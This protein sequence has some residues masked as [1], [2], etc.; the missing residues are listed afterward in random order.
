MT[1]IPKDIPLP[2]PAPEPLL[3]FLLVI[4]FLLHILFVNLMAGGALLTVYYQVRGLKEPAYDAL[5]REISRTITVNKSLAVV[6]GVGPLLAINTLYTVY[7]YSASALIGG[8]WI[9]IVP[10]VTIAFLLAY[11][12]KYRW[13]AL[14]AHRRMHIALGA[15]VAGLFLFVPMIFLANANLMLFPARWT[16]V[17]GL[18]SALALPGVLPRYLHF[19]LASLAF[20]GLFLVWVFRRPE[21]LARLAEAGFAQETLIRLGYR[22]AFFATLAQ[23]AVGPLILITLPSEGLSTAMVSVILGGAALALAA[24]GVM[25]LELRPG[26]A[27]GSRLWLVAGLLGATVVFMGSG[28][29]VYRETALAAHKELVRTRTERYMQEA[30]DANRALP[31]AP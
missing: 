3:A 13:D 25:F 27:A 5:A 29:H 19:V 4:F 31:P 23:F 11:L 7:F 18:I 6:L 21:P 2:L 22:W 8:F 10:L 30:A 12:H 26:A 9:A 24:L 16:E 1:P 28:R 20:A 14:N 15:V 17:N